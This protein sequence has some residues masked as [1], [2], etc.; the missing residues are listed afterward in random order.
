M[1]SVRQ[2]PFA[3]G[4]SL[5]LAAAAAAA[6]ERRREG[7]DDKGAGCLGIGP[8]GDGLGVEAPDEV[9]IDDDLVRERNGG[10]VAVV[11]VL[12]VVGGGGE[13]GLVDSK[14]FV[15]L[16]WHATQK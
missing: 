5:S 8:V 7:G 11:N 12:V 6:A 13:G 9:A 16:W 4:P 14:R 15:K 1:Q 2:H 3:L 10:I